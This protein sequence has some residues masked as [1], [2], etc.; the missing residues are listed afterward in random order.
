MKNL[1]RK[2]LYYMLSIREKTLSYRLSKSLK[3]S[4]QNKTSK[5]IL[6]STE[7]LT[8]TIETE[9]NKELVRKNVEDIVK[10]CPNNPHK[11]LE[12]IQAEGTKVYKIPNA[13]KILT[14]IGEDEGLIC[15]LRGLKAL[16]LNLVTCSKFSFT[17]T[18][19][20]VMREG[21]TDFL[22]M[23]HQ[24]YK[25]YSMKLNLPGFDYKA[26]QNFK[27]YLKNVNDATLSTLS[28]ED[29]L[30]LSEAVQRDKEATDFALSFAQK[31][32]GA[33]NVHEKMTRGGA[34]I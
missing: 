19:A 32:E 25:W 5:T 10:N 31:T 22:H 13:D 2:I 15:E 33:K 34:D 11:L 24:F 4:Y 21:N 1:L 3:N 9:K 14:A 23:L 16:Y 27:K 18:P 7:H 12:Y 8:L 29:T 26:Q 6:S 28:L 20:F 30:A 17:F